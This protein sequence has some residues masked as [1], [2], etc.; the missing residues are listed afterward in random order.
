MIKAHAFPVAPWLLRFVDQSRGGQVAEEGRCP[1]V[2]AERHAQQ[3][4]LVRS[5]L[6]CSG[7]FEGYRRSQTVRKV[8]KNLTDRLLRSYL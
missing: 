6:N 4:R 1:Q 7:G 2:E 8:S 5:R 3:L